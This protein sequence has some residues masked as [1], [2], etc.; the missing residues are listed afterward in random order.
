MDLDVYFTINVLET[1]AKTP[2]ITYHYV[3]AVVI[4]L[5][6]AGVIVP[7]TVLGLCIAVHM[8]AFGLKFI[9]RPYGVLAPK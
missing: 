5:V 7:G 8:V 2:G 4:I 1:F 3:D 6:V 9:K